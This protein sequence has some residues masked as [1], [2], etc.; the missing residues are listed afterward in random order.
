MHSFLANVYS[1]SFHYNFLIEQLNT[2]YGNIT[3]W[4]IHCNWKCRKSLGREEVCCRTR[5]GHQC[6]TIIVVPDIL[7]ERFVLSTWALGNTVHLGTWALEH[8]KQLRTCEHCAVKH[9]S[10]MSSWGEEFLQ[11]YGQQHWVGGGWGAWAGPQP[12]DFGRPRNC[13]FGRDCFE[14]WGIVLW[15]FIIYLID[16]EPQLNF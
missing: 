3:Q 2:L 6:W 4:S 12:W 11:A 1:D 7:T 15:A 16:P 5:W 10:T 13:D 14:K 9:L 8:F